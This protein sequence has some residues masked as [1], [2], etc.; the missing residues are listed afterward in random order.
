MRSIKLCILSAVDASMKAIDRSVRTVSV[1]L[2][3]FT[4]VAL[5]VKLNA[6]RSSQHTQNFVFRSLSMDFFLLFS[7]FA[8]ASTFQWNA[9]WPLKRTKYTQHVNAVNMKIE[10]N[11][12]H[13]FNL[14]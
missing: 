5:I 8:R 3:N 1:S 14:N 11:Y 4:S 10:K 9:L 7:T 2:K 6:L 12:Y 13:Y